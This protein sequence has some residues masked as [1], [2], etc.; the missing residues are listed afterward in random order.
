MSR[1]FK[2]MMI[3][4]AGFV[5]AAFAQ[6]LQESQDA[7]DCQLSSKT[8]CNFY[9]GCLEQKYNCQQTD[10]R[11][12]IEYGERFC[13][14]FVQSRHLLTVRG[15]KWMDRAMSCL[16]RSLH[17]Q[18]LLT[19]I[20]SPTDSS[21]SCQKIEQV[22]FASHHPC[23]VQ[24]TGNLQDGVCPLWRDYKL[25]FEIGRPWEAFGTAN[26]GAVRDQVV[27]TAKSCIGYWLTIKRQK[28]ASL[29]IPIDSILQTLQDVI[30]A[31]K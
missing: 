2:L 27:Q 12:P 15:Q 26:E 18:L 21:L 17:Q 3:M 16:Q 20:L 25:I 7:I 31:E 10:F 29:D 11:Y 4:G 23:Y 6:E 24:P 1:L 14:S 19:D 5:F 22:A 13:S 30:Q 9:S 28:K 8:T